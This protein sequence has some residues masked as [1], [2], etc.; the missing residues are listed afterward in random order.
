MAADIA[1]GTTFAPEGSYICLY[2][3][4]GSLSF[5]V[6]NQPSSNIDVSACFLSNQPGESLTVLTLHV[7]KGCP[8]RIT[9]ARTVR[10]VFQ[11]QTAEYHC[12]RPKFVLY[13][14]PCAVA[15]RCSHDRRR[16]SRPYSAC[17]N[18]FCGSDD[19]HHQHKPGGSAAQHSPPASLCH[20]WWPTRDVPPD[21]P[22]TAGGVR[23]P[24]VPWHPRLEQFRCQLERQQTKGMVRPP[25]NHLSNPGWASWHGYGVRNPAGKRGECYCQQ[26]YDLPCC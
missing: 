20:R 10:F 6:R 22:L 16:H 23:P 14:A 2:D 18:S 13:A 26:R 25:H 9:P 24:K 15:G 1:R 7:R 5:E 19:S 8:A 12:F 3:G 11:R 21:A 4:D 17:H